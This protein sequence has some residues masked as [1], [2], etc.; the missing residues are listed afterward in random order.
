MLL[1]LESQHSLGLA[2]MMLALWQHLHASASHQN[3]CIIEV[4]SSGTGSLGL[5]RVTLAAVHL[6]Q[7]LHTTASHHMTYI[8]EGG[9]AGTGS[10]PCTRRREVPRRALK[11]LLKTLLAT[12]GEPKEMQRTSASGY[13]SAAQAAPAH[14]STNANHNN[15][16]HAC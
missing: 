11:A 16:Q 8:I 1:R 3:T 13:S 2:R 15:N 5:A 7:H 14:N 4:G 12:R 10:K 6:Q 9:R